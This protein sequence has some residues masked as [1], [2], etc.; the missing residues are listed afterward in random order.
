MSISPLPFN[1]SSWIDEHA[2]LLKPPVG[3]QQIWQDRDFIVTIV[4]GPNYRTDYHDDPGEEFFYQLR[5][6][7]YLNLWVDG[8]AQR[9]DLREGDVFLLPP[10]ARHSP[11]RPESGSACLV[12][13]RQR[14]EGEIDAFEWYCDQ[15]GGCGHLVHRTEV[16]LKNIVTDLPPLFDAFY[17]SETLRCCPNCGKV[18][19]GKGV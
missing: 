2:H 10:H 3:N 13:E 14:P 9:V 7:A 11:Q 1:L 18:H 17:R 12:I 5:G 16:Q 4:G 15:D 8:A 6:N 19:P